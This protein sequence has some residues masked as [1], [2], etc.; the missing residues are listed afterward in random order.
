MSAIV[1]AEMP[2]ARLEQIRRRDREATRRRRA[3]VRGLPDPGLVPDRSMAEKRLKLPEG[4]PVLGTWVLHGA[5]RGQDPELWFS[6]DPADLQRAQAICARCPVRAQ[7]SAAA[8]ANPE[9]YGVW[10]GTDR[11]QAARAS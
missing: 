3:I 6:A 5:C 8:E 11:A 7:C 1:R 9:R 4:R 2:A 10:G